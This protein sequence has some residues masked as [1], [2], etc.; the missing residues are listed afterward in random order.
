MRLLGPFA[1]QANSATRAF[2]YPWLYEQLDPAPGR[3]IVDLGAG[4][5][6]LQF[7]MAA[8]GAEVTTVDP[9]I[10]PDEDLVW[11]FSDVEYGQLN[12]A[13]GNR[14]RFIRKFLEDAALPSNAFDRVVA[15]SVIEHIPLE[16]ALSIMREIARILKPGGRFAATID[17]FLDCVPFTSQPRNMWGSN[18][19]VRA[20][21]EAS[22]LRMVVGNPAELYGYA[23]FNPDTIRAN[24]SRYLVVNDVLTQCIVLEKA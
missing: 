11:V 14:V 2:E 1:F 8:S 17:L 4:A 16:A 18:V 20:L 13:F 10:N 7:V 21:V 24:L 19:S 12:R 6:G 3:K 15:C 23:E 9:L 22:G 5:S